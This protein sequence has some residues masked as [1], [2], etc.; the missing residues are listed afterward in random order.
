M[1]SITYDRFDGG[2]DVRRGKSVSD[3]NRLRGLTNAYVTTGRTLQKR[4]CLRRVATLEAGTVGLRAGLGK[5]HTFYGQGSVTHADTLFQA[6]LIPHPTSALNV[7]KVHFGEVFNGYL[8]VAAEYSDGS[9][10]HHYLDD[11]GAWV[12]TTAYSLG[13]FRR[14]TTA[15]GFRYEVTSNGTSGGVE[16]TW[17]T[18]VGFTVVDGTVTWTCRSRA[19]VDTNCPHTKELIKQQSKIYAKGDEVVR[20]CATNAPRDWTTTSDAGFLPTG[21]QA[22]GSTAT[23]AVGQFGQKKLA[24]FFSDGIQIWDVDPNPSLNA[25]NSIIPN[26]GTR[27]S[28]TPI[29]FGGDNF[30]LADPGFRSVTVASLTNNFQDLDIGNAIDKLV[31]PVNANA[32]P[33]SQFYPAL[34]QYWCI[35]DQTIWVY[36]FSRLAKLAA[37]SKFTLPV[38]ADAVA[39]LNGDLYIRSGDVVYIMD[40]ARYSDDG[41]PPTVTIEMPFLD[42]KEPGVLK[43]II[44]VDIVGTGNLSL[45]LKFD[46][47]DESKVTNA[48]AVASGDT[49]PG[50]MTPVE[51]C[52]VAVAPVITHVGDEDFRI[53]AITFYYE[54][55][56]PHV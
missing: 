47:N 14:P 36:S 23:T 18:T 30:F 29:G 12:A 55:L 8:Y 38:T 51:M 54:A 21:L 9:I 32:D 45:Q 7:S 25:L 40:M 17:P 46:P 2:L 1:P 10:K 39:V 24:I 42:F 13:A 34:G 50:A 5:L 35:D 33:I 53:D 16:P 22:L 41:V 3:A 26:I 43:Q 52:A 27:F 15:N 6:N 48:L 44:G 4:P 37:W 49:R 19:I 20:Y 31:S 11:P 56:G 28:K